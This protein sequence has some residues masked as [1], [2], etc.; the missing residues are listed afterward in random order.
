MSI[1]HQINKI[2]EIKEI[3]ESNK[4]DYLFLTRSNLNYQMIGG[5]CNDSTPTDD[6]ETGTCGGQSYE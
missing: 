4:R 3:Y 6:P 2:N 5:G 1:Q